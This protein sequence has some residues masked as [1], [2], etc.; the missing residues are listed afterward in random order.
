MYYDYIFCIKAWWFCFVPPVPGYLLEE[1]EHK[2]DP[3]FPN[4]A[5]NYRWTIVTT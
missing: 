3:S 2:P 4:L 1:E 5:R